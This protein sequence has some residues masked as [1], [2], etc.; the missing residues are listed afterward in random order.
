MSKISILKVWSLLIAVSFVLYW[1]HIN[2]TV[3][4]RHSWAMADHFAIALNFTD[5][6]FDFLHPQTYCLNPQFSPTKNKTDE[7]WSVVPENAKGITAIDFPIH[8]FAVAGLMEL[9]N[10]RSP[11]VFRAYMLLLSLIGLFYL[12]KTA[13]IVTRSSFIGILMVSFV[14]LSPTFSYYAIGFLPSAASF[15]LLFVGIYLYVQDHYAKNSNSFLFS[16]FFLTLAALARFP[17]VIY[18][19][20]LFLNYAIESFKNKHIE[21]K[22]LL[23]VSS[24]IFCVLLYF[25]YN[26][27]YLLK[28]FGSNF[29]SYPIFPKSLNEFVQV[30]IKTMYHESWRYFT[31][32]HYILIAFTLGFLFK[33]KKN[34]SL[35][36]TNRPLIQSLVIASVG[37]CCY[38]FLMSSQFVAHDYY[39]LDTFLPILIFWMLISLSCMGQKKRALLKK[40]FLIGGLLALVMNQVVY[41]FQGYAPRPET[42]IFRS[43][44]NFEKS[45][46]VLDS[47][48][49]PKSAKILLIDAYSPNLAF[50]GMQRKGYSVMQPNFNNIQRAL[51]WDYDYIITQNF[52]YLENVLKPYPNFE[53]ETSV[54]YTNSNFTIHLKK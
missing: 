3:Q 39:I 35:A 16:I 27:F 51:N 43:R 52:S 1:N 6:H 21:W 45:H 28:N 14:F 46:K 23:S 32:I 36:K 54:Y 42:A 47:L 44:T 10:T 37:V 38:S 19:I 24:G 15:A 50:I 2:D 29:L 7:F 5:N 33:L 4:G 20:A 26:K 31:L 49:I 40:Y 13:L 53:N 41:H 17:F 34:S 9:F 25:S 8:H 30:L 11:L 18:L 12:Y 48:Q 22:K